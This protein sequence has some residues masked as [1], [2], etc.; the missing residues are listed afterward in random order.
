MTGRSVNS[1]VD[2][3]KNNIITKKNT[4][5]KGNANEHEKLKLGPRRR[6]IRLRRI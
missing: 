5:T 4:E 6:K 1:N 3:K 2:N